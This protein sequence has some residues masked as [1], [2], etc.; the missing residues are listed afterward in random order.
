MTTPI[1]EDGELGAPVEALSR[2]D[3]APSEAFLGRVRG[4]IRRRQ[5]A[6]EAAE[7]TWTGLSSVLLEY[8]ELV[9]SALGPPAGRERESGDGRDPEEPR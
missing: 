5:L 6:G 8:L 2:L 1:D 7:L 4:S 3:Q 9:F